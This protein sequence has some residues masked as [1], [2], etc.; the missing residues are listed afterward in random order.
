MIKSKLPNPVG[1][2]ELPAAGQVIEL[3]TMHEFDNLYER[4]CDNGLIVMVYSHDCSHCHHLKPVYISVAKELPQVSFAAIQASVAQPW[5]VPYQL[6][7][8][9]SVLAF[10]RRGT[11]PRYVHMLSHG[12][13][14]RLRHDL[15][16]FCTSEATYP[17]RRSRLKKLTSPFKERPV[18]ILISRRFSRIYSLYQMHLK[19]GEGSFKRYNYERHAFRSNFF[20]TRNSVDPTL[21][22]AEK[23]QELIKLMGRSLV[24][25]VTGQVKYKRRKNSTVARWFYGRL[26]QGRA[27]SIPALFG[28]GVD[29]D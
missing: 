28:T 19:L 14:E 29:R 9:P 24:Q 16:C 6:T 21:S 2:D 3:S 10:G 22:S 18:K 20:P 4:T 8:T 23:G 1:N 27:T 5:A 25:S 12:S 7:G 13:A 26:Q 11:H 17:P 15:E